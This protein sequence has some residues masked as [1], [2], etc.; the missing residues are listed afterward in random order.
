[1]SAVCDRA[2]AQIDE[3]HYIDEFVEDGYGSFIK[4]GICFCKKNCRVKC[5]TQTVE[6][7]Y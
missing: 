4:Y 5:A 2:L 1:M 7:N 3:N 6:I